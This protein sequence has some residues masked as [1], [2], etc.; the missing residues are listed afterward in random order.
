VAVSGATNV[1]FSSRAIT[2]NDYTP[3]PVF[4]G[5]ADSDALLLSCSSSVYSP[6]AWSSAGTLLT[7]L[8]SGD[9]RFAAYGHGSQAVSPSGGEVTIP[10]VTFEVSP[11][12]GSTIGLVLFE[13]APTLAWGQLWPRGNW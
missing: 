10:A 11:Q 3:S 5:G 1:S 6:G 7:S 9:E 12:Q 13:D 8:A 2:T 4:P